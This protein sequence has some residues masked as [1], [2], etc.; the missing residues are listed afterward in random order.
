MHTQCAHNACLRARIFMFA[1]SFIARSFI[2]IKHTVSCRLLAT[3][4]S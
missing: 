2:V 3:M 4:A 1:T